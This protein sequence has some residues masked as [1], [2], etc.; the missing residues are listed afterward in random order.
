[1][2]RTAAGRS[3]QDGEFRLIIPLDASGIE[4]LK[5]DQHVKVA[6]Q[7]RTGALR[8]H[9]VELDDTGHGRATF[10]FPAASNFRKC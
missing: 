8:S 2:A 5:P 4:D 7:D 3:G 6:V 9:V 10:A 1:M